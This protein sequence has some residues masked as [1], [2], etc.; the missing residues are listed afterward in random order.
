MVW[1]LLSDRV[2]RLAVARPDDI[3]WLQTAKGW[4]FVAVSA[5]VIYLLV[6]RRLVR[7]HVLQARHRESETDRREVERELSEKERVLTTLMGNLPGMAYRC[8]NDAHWTMEFVSEGCRALTGYAPE[9][10]VGNAAIAYAELINPDDREAVWS[11]VQDGLEAG[12]AF[13]LT[14]RIS[15]AQGEERWV[16]EQGSG[17]FAEDGTL[18]A[19]E[20]F[21]TDITE[22]KHLESQLLQA[23]RLES[24]GQLAGGISHDFN[25][26]L[27]AILGYCELVLRQVEAGPLREDVME[28]QKAAKRGSALTGQL[29]AFTRKRES[30]LRVLRLNDVV[31]DVVGMLGRLVG[32]SVELDVRLDPALGCVKANP[33]QVEQIL[34]N[35]VVNA[36]DAMPEGG[37][38]SIETANVELDEAY[39][40]THRSAEPGPH[41]MIAVSDTGI[42]MDEEIRSRIFE[43]FFTT[44]APGTGTGLGLST[45]YSI[46]KQSGGNI[47]IYSTPGLGTTFKVHLP[48][49]SEAGEPLVARPAPAELL[50]GSE[51]VL[52]VDD[53]EALR[54]LVGQVLERSGYR[55]LAAGEGAAALNRAGEHDGPIHL[56]VTDLI[57]PGLT[58]LDLA[59]RL[60][61]SRPDMK[62]LYISGHSDLGVVRP[63]AIEP[64]LAF[65]QKPFTP[66]ALLGKV[67]HVLDQPAGDR[68][69]AARAS[70]SS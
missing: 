33:S 46:V 31:N 36:R 10:L 58:G 53:E 18:L 67:R 2:V 45:V 65:L 64:G 52:V 17:V 23:A 4:L 68:E 34:M 14:Y 12:G 39:A 41:V 15:T 44:K 48:R 9:D 8:R 19:L 1:I 54:L 47:W 13:Q 38:I 42:G 40:A 51:T 57:L 62:V 27:A 6:H 50:G 30:Q 5:L 35:L 60:A 16:W 43:P 66:S 56:L 37:R 70:G 63:G 59:E 21:I 7:I 29:L 11:G 49:V 55:V 24:I 25:N 69:A 26:V 3:T 32:Q 20:G 22:R 61:I 28:I